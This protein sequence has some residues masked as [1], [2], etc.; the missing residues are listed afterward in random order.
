MTGTDDLKTGYAEFSSPELDATQAFFASAFGWCFVEHGP[1]SR[2]SRNAGLGG[3]S[4]GGKPGYPLVVVKTADLQ[5]A[6]YVVRKPSV[7]GVTELLFAS[8]R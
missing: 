6:P 4:E 1:G 8:T 5:K 2:D 3:E 7:S